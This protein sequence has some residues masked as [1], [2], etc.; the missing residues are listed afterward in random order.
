MPQ[1]IITAVDR[2]RFVLVLHTTSSVRSRSFGRTDGDGLFNHAALP[3]PV[4]VRA[5]ACKYAYAHHT[6]TTHPSPLAWEPATNGQ[7]IAHCYLSKL[8]AGLPDG[9]I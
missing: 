7:L 1:I 3:L 8:N 2:R 9:K 5:C 6:T 4:H